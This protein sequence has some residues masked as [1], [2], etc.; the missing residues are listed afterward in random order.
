MSL[1]SSSEFLF[2]RL[3][4]GPLPV[5]TF[6]LPVLPNWPPRP[7]SWDFMSLIWLLISPSSL[8]YKEDPVESPN[9][10]SRLLN[11]FVSS[12]PLASLPW[13]NYGFAALPAFILWYIKTMKTVAGTANGIRYCVENMSD[14]LNGSGFGALAPSGVTAA[15]FTLKEFSKNRTEC[16][17]W[18]H[19]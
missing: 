16:C 3:F 19:S 1:K 12:V 5:S 10:F 18:D 15:K 8:P 7:P 4:T 9:D 14:H 2:I 17:L 11:R 13:G 6:F